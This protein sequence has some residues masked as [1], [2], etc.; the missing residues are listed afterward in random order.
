[1]EVLI[2]NRQKK[3]KLNLR[4]IKTIAREIMEFEQLEENCELSIVFCDD[5]FI[6]KL[7]NE[8]L[9]RNRPTDVLAFPIE[10]SDFEP[11][12]K[13]L[14][15]VVISIETASRQALKFRHSLGLEIVFLLTHGILHLLGYDHTATI[16]EM[17]KMKQK[18]ENIFKHLCEKKMLRG[19]DLICPGQRTR[20][21]L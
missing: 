12:V 17:L 3:V 5:D 21:N 8:Y 7:N 20:K 1:M 10:E 2:S 18:E 15:D 14:G 9:G 13:L 19:I 4:K 16:S 11:E 6:Q